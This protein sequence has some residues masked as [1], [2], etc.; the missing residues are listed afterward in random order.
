MNCRLAFSV[1]LVA[2]EVLARS[3][4]AQPA[5]IEFGPGGEEVV[6]NPRV[7]ADGYKVSSFE[8]K[9][10]WLG[11]MPIPLQPGDIW[12]PQKQS[13]V[14]NAIRVAFTGDDVTSY[15]VGQQGEAR[16]FYVDVVEEKD[17]VQRTVKL[18]FRPFN[19]HVSLVKV[20]DNVL[21]IP[22]SPFA[23]RYSAVPAPLL[24]LN[25]SAGMSYD[26]AFGTALLGA[27]DTDLLALPETARGKLPEPSPHHLDA[28]FR[29]AKSFEEF[30]RADAGLKYSVRQ[31][32]RALAEMFLSA[33]FAS[34]NEPLADAKNR[35]NAAAGLAGATVRLG[36][37]TRVTFNAGYSHEWDELEDSGM[38]MRTSTDVQPNRLVA[39]SLLPK[40]LRGFLRAAI[41]EDNAWTDRG[42]GA[43]QRL[44]GRI[45]YAREFPVAPNQTIGLELLAG[46]GHVWGDAPAP[47]RFFGGNSPGQFLYDSVSSPH[48][49]AMP[50]GPLIRSFG[51]AEANGDRGRAVGGG[52]AFWHL[53]ANLTVPIRP[54][55][56]PLIP[57]E[58]EVREMLRNGIFTSGRNFLITALKNQGM[59]RE[60]AVAEA[61]KT[62]NEIRPATEFIIDE[63]NL[64]AVK[65]LLMFDAAGLSGG[66]RDSTWLAAGG[67]V[68]LTIVTARLELGYMHTLRGPVDDDRGNF[69]ARL[70]FQNLF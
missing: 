20:G 14:L 15:V 21:P 54:W 70:I 13:E 52:D 36:A 22:R 6:R 63:A 23:T 16:V 3:C 46:A 51:E 35:Q 24:A 44:I 66:G 67:G 61:D 7:T 62:F 31:T 58:A 26:R 37:H 17:E 68:Q 2:C 60:E 65:P 5:V 55:S 29:G 1:V 40:P 45:G 11:A 27:F 69:F 47:R 9:G 48:L 43:H 30:Y 42:V 33:D 50:Q 12:S 41:W 25:P 19:V 18:T 4:F 49:V 64:Y 56:R 34:A 10:R 59:S 38:E 8:I 39:D 53:N 57:A 32:G 28:R